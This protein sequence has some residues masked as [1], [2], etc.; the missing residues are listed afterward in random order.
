MLAVSASA[1]GYSAAVVDECPAKKYKPC[2]SF[3]TS[4]TIEEHTPLM[5]NSLAGYI[6]SKGRW[7]IHLG[8][9]PSATC[10]KVSLTVDMGP[11][12]MHRTYERIFHNGRGVVT[13]SGTFLHPTDEVESGLRIMTSSCWWLWKCA[14]IWRTALVN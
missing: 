14:V 11:L 1:A 9:G 3:N 5:E 10:A 12:D 4:R 7:S 8:Y 2:A 13:D 6:R